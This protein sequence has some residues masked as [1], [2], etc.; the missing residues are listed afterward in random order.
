MP[1]PIGAVVNWSVANGRG[2]VGTI[3]VPMSQGATVIQWTCGDDVASFQITGLDSAEFTPSQSSAGAT[4]FSS[5]DRADTAGDY[6]YTVTAVRSS[7][8]EQS[9]HDPKIENV[10]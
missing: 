2:E 8:G 10:P 4:S 7:T 6:S 9:R 5:T 1:A 3:T